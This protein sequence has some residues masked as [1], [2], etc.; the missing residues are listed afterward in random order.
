[1]TRRMFTVLQQ[2]GYDSPSNRQAAVDQSPP[3]PFTS[4]RMDGKISLRGFFWIRTASRQG[5]C[6]VQQGVH[7]FRI[8]EE[9]IGWT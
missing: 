4:N 2:P 8:H 7:G 3:G 6:T 9:R 5:G 1:M